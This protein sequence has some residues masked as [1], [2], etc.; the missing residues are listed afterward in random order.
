MGV[1]TR[2]REFLIVKHAGLREFGIYIFARDVGTHLDCG[3][4]L[5]VAPGS[6][7]RMFSKKMTGDP[8]ALSQNIGVFSQQDLSAWKHI[9]HRMMV[10]HIREIMREVKM[11]DAGMNT[12]SKGYLSVW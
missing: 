1:M 7:K 2:A 4:F 11:D 8:N 10:K 3:W 12:Q 5:T 6:F 9:L